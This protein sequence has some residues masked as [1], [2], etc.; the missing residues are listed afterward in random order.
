MAS[1][2][3]VIA[4]KRVVPSD[5]LRLAMIDLRR[6]GERRRLSRE[7]ETNP[8]VDRMGA[9]RRWAQHEGLF[10]TPFSL[11]CAPMCV[12]SA[13]RSILDASLVRG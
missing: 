12:V 11:T 3:A 1:V 10:T 5:A 9:S 13:S 2:A 4:V 6:A 7:L 8:Y